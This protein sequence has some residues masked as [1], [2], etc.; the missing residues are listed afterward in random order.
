MGNATIF[1]TRNR[2]LL[3]ACAVTILYTNKTIIVYMTK[4]HALAQKNVVYTQRQSN[5]KNHRYLMY[6]L[7]DIDLSGVLRNN[8]GMSKSS[9]IQ[10]T[11]MRIFFWYTYEYLN[12]KYRSY[13]CA[14]SN[15]D[16]ISLVE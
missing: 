10:T 8:T 5:K 15:Y 14:Y 6:L 12:S 4:N 7:V 11:L 9:N 3:I 2:N 13:S 16:H 1:I